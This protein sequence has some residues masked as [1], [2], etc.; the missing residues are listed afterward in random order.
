[1]LPVLLLTGWWF[2][3]NQTL[4]GDPL[5]WSMFQEVYRVVMRTTPLAWNDVRQFFNT[6]IDSFAGV[7]GWMNVRA[8]PVYYRIV[9]ICGLLG[10]VGLAPFFARYRKELSRDQR[11][12]LVFLAF[13]IVAQECY[14]LWAIQRFDHPGIRDAT[15]LPSS[16]PS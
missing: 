8:T 1:M 15:C 9:R 16:V 11:A 14:L 2:V 5:G 7:F 6:Q 4:Y 12:G 3:R 13:T 10:L